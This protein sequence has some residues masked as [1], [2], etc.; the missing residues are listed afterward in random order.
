MPLLQEYKKLFEQSNNIDRI[1]DHH[2]NVLWPSKADPNSIPFYVEN[3]TDQLKTLRMIPNNSAPVL[4]IEISHDTKTWSL[5]GTTSSTLTYDLLPTERVYLRCQTDR[6]Y[7]TDGNGYVAIRGVSKIG[8][9]IM[10]LLY[11]NSFTG[12]ETRFP[13][14]DGYVFNNMFAYSDIVD[15]SELILPV[16]ELTEYC[17]RQMFLYASSLVK[18]PALPAATLVRGCYIYMF[19]YCTALNEVKCYAEYGINTNSTTSSWISGVGSTGTFY[20]K[21]GVTWP[22]G[23]NGIP[24]GWT[25][26]EV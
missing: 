19:G 5:L 4:Y 26:V 3:T 11:G 12:K 13:T 15:A 22:S 17:Y 21:A 2:G 24:D 9:N 20:K 7:N 1:L 23:T 25:V 14:S 8:G 16:T 18:A 10:S 6:W